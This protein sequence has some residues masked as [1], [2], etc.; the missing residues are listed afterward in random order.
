[1][2]VCV[3]VF[4]NYTHQKIANGSPKLLLTTP[5]R[6]RRRIA[7]AAR[8]VPPALLLRLLLQQPTA[9]QPVAIALHAAQATKATHPKRRL[10]LL[11]WVCHKRTA[12]AAVKQ[13]TKGTTQVPSAQRRRAWLQ[14]RQA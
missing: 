5:T 4:Q 13:A 14:S 12:S 3:C 10:P 9:Q 8:A 7:R 2:S 6:C 11:G 1:M